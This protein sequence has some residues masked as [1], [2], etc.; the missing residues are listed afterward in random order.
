MFWSLLHFLAESAPV[1][2]LSSQL[3]Q[4]FLAA[5][6]PSISYGQN[7]KEDS[8]E[9]RQLVKAFLVCQVFL[10]YDL[11][12]GSKFF[13]TSTKREFHAEFLNFSLYWRT[14]VVRRKVNSSTA[15]IVWDSVR[16]INHQRQLANHS[17]LVRALQK[18]LPD[19]SVSEAEC[20]IDDC[21]ED[22]VLM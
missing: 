5:C 7:F 14:M 6:G 3:H 1:T 21:I 20:A 9:P 19:L 15:I 11:R 2:D 13:I 10:P 17:R 4:M 22:G 12:V 18:E 16:R 8:L